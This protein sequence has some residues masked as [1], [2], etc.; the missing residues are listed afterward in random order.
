LTKCVSNIELAPNYPKGINKGNLGKTP[1]RRSDLAIDRVSI[2]NEE[3]TAFNR[4]AVEAKVR[5]RPST[6]MKTDP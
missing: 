4:S 2:A 1:E 5:I 3:A 6:K